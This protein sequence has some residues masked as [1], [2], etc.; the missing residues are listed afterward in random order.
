MTHIWNSVITGV[1]LIAL[2]SKLQGVFPLLTSSKDNVVEELNNELF[3]ALV[4]P[5]QAK[6]TFFQ[7]PV[8]PPR[9]RP[10]CFEITIILKGVR[11]N[12]IEQVELIHSHIYRDLVTRINCIRKIRPFLAEFPV[13]PH[14]LYLNILFFD[15]SGRKVRPPFFSSIVTEPQTIRFNQYATKEEFDGNDPNCGPYYKIV[16]KIPIS[17]ADWLKEFFTSSLSRKS[18]NFKTL[19]PT[20]DQPSLQN[21]TVGGSLFWFAKDFCHHHGLEVVLAGMTGMTDEDLRVFNFVLRGN[22]CIDLDMARRLAGLCSKDLLNFVRTDR[23]CLDHMK[24]RSTW[25]HIKDPSTFPELRHTAFR[26]SFWDENVDRQPAPYIA[27]IRVIGEKFSYF[28]SDEN[29]RLVLVHEETFEEALSFLQELEN[30]GKELLE[31][32]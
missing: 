4:K 27:E 16:K 1:I 12:S 10:F 32:S 25:K 24:E 13:T 11:C 3:E 7:G 29:Q 8:M 19:I 22:Q 26:I 18:G 28:T 20:Y 9:G 31:R 6:Y 17:E 23:A 2:M 30:K 21:S 15:E 14:T 5:N